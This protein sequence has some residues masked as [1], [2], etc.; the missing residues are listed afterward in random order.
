MLGRR[1]LENCYK[2]NLVVRSAAECVADSSVE[3]ELAHGCMPAVSLFLLADSKLLCCW[4]LLQV[5][6]PEERERNR[7]KTAGDEESERWLGKRKGRRMERRAIQ[8]EKEGK[9]KEK[10]WDIRR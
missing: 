4:Q 9:G 2:A 5:G 3:V 10:E 1:L 7:K 8:R 6:F